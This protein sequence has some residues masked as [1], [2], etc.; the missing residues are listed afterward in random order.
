[1][2]AKWDQAETFEAYLEAK[3]LDHA[4]WQAA[5]PAVYAEQA[6]LFAEV[7]PKSYDHLKKFQINDWRLAYPALSEAERAGKSADKDSS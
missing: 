4:A 2:S 1:M 7:G 5:E 6:A 3:K